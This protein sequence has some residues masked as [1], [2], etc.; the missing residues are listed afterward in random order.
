MLV[1]NKKG[2]VAGSRRKERQKNGKGERR[3]DG[4]GTKKKMAVKWKW[5]GKEPKS[6]ILYIALL[7]K[8]VLTRAFVVEIHHQA[9]RKKYR[10]KINNISYMFCRSSQLACK[11]QTLHKTRDLK[12][13]S[14]T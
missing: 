7:T 5:K 1:E 2:M 11:T 6:M 12:M 13:R 8:G 10:A 3:V 4:G 14:P 9:T